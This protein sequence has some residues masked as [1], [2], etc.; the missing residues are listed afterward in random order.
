MN[1]VWKPIPGW[2]DRYE[3][4]NI[5][6]VRSIVFVRNRKVYPRETPIPVTQHLLRGYPRVYLCKLG[7]KMAYFV[8][9]LVLEAF[10]G[11]SNGLDGAHLD[12]NP[13]NSNLTNLVWATRSENC[14][15]KELHG[16]AQKGEKNPNAKLTDVDV[17]TMRA[18]RK[19]GWKL[20][21]LAKKY[22]TSEPRVS[23]IVRG[24]DWK[25]LPL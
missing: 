7:I 17:L 22:N 15:H 5:G 21:D 8:H 18:L 12:G 16:T 19:E 4:S 13:S 25:H 11:P 9:R 10:V 24:N 1:E 3:V 23:N 6:N 20:K 2:E 14:R